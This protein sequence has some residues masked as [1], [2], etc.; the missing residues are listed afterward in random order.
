MIACNNKILCLA[1]ALVLLTS[2]LTGCVQESLPSLGISSALPSTTVT[3]PG[4]TG[5]VPMPTMTVTLP[6]TTVPTVPPTTVPSVPPTTVPTVP[7]TTA[8]TTPPT[9][10]PTEPKPTE[11]TRPKPTE[12]TKPSTTAPT[13]PE[14]S[15]TNIPA[16]KIPQLHAQNAFI[17]DT[18]N[19]HFLYSSAAVEV[20]VYPASTTKLFTSYVALQY[21]QVDQ[22]VTVGNELSYVT[23]DST[24]AG[25]RKGDVV[26]VENL[27][28][29]AMLPSGCDASYIL[30]AAAGR[31]ILK[32][33]NAS[34][35]E[36][37]KAFVSECNR[38]AKTL[39]MINTNLA[40]PDGYHH[41]KH[42][43][44]LQ[45]LAIV[46]T[47]ALE[48]ELLARVC[49][50]NEVTI[51]YKNKD[52]KSCSA[53]LYNTNYLIQSKSTYYH[54]LAVGLKTGTTGPAGACLLA[55]YQV[56]GGYILVGVF[57][58]NTKDGRFSDANALFEACLPYL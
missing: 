26:S 51:T 18:R 16:S 20:I 19:N 55:A 1:L 13:E 6:S 37:I 52:G 47:L 23:D 5:T 9:T 4:T 27:I 8:P 25:F 15:L 3:Q 56:P 17:F 11:T 43:F 2:A 45:A 34:V 14:Q 36:A 10:K 30:A 28:Y 58:C 21:L 48:H 35:K 42:Y 33:E 40:N 32:N 49:A 44:S 12:T 38:Q 39:G 46:G 22:T 29:G 41:S 57:G 24:I 50:T 53:T 54:D 31:V 7:P